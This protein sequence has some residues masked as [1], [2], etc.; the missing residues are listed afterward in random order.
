[1]DIF[2]YW[3]NDLTL[4]PT[5]D[6]APVDSTQWGQQ[7]ILRRLITNPATHLFGNPGDLSA[8]YIW[9]PDFGAGLPEAVGT[10]LDVGLLSGLIRSQI[11][12][13]AAVAKTPDPVVTV[14]P[15]AGGVA[16]YIKYADAVSGAPVVLSFDINN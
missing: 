10:P 6:L 2:H 12:L 3:G 9:H 5:G 1:M 7:R 16:V 14:T 4:G 13:E 11:M 15:I 8:D